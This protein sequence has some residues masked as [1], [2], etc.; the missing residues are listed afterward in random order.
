M[1]VAAAS[2]PAPHALH[3]PPFHLPELRLPFAPIKPA[4]SLGQSTCTH[5]LFL[6]EALSSNSPLFPLFRTQSQKRLRH[7]LP[8]PSSYVSCDSGEPGAHLPILHACTLLATS[9]GHP[10]RVPMTPST[11]ETRHRL[12]RR[13]SSRVNE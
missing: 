1:D 3:W 5:S 10:D 4:L 13:A 12:P 9:Q 8:P 6:H 11:D 2:S 7:S